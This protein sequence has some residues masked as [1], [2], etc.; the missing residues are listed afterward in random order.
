[1]T[2]ALVTEAA[3]PK[4]EGKWLAK[5]QQYIAKKKL[6]S[7][8]AQYRWSSNHSMIG[9]TTERE[10][11]LVDIGWA[12]AASQNTDTPRERLEEALFAN[13]SQNLEYEP[14]TVSKIH[15]LTTSS[16]IYSYSQDTVLDPHA[17]FE[18]LG[19]PKPPNLDML[20]R[21][22]A[23]DLTAEAMSVPCST[24]LALATLAVVRGLSQ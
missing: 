11:D 23:F 14:F 3:A 5:H 1:M 15:A 20:S 18:F 8:L 17:H 12:E 2:E 19:W 6:G 21:A 24:A 9:V 13:V 7:S 16:K 4:P 10:R 22:Q